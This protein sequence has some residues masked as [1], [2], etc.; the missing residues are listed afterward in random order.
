M[1]SLHTRSCVN[2][3][4]TKKKK[5]IQ[6]L[7]RKNKAGKEKQEKADEAEY[8]ETILNEWL[9]NL[10]WSNLDHKSMKGKTQAK[11]LSFVLQ[12]KEL[13]A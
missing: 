4:Y 10:D 12:G 5:S 9:L 13:V 7:Q 8:K 3:K 2:T 1:V 6:R 11:K